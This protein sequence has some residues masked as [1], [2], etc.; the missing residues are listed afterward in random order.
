M[1]AELSI[2]LGT[3]TLLFPANWIV[4]VSRP[5][6]YHQHIH[7]YW[8][9]VVSSSVH[10]EQDNRLSGKSADLFRVRNVVLKY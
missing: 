9:L 8:H 10:Y 3:G 1:I 5:I 7:R 4:L 6:K 2:V